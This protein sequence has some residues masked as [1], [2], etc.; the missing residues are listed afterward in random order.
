MAET[1]K[2]TKAEAPKAQDVYKGI[3]AAVDKLWAIR[4]AKVKELCENF[5]LKQKD[6]ACRKIVADLLDHLHHIDADRQLNWA[7]HEECFTKLAI[8]SDVIAVENFSHDE[9][10]SRCEQL[11]LL[12]QTKVA[13]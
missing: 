7:K 13:Q 11:A 10:L 4:Q 3:L 1:K 2:H 9:A 12:I 5:R 6:A 8:L